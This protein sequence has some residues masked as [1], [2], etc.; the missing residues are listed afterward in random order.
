MRTAAAQ[1]ATVELIL[2]VCAAVD[3]LL[4][5]EH[6]VSHAPVA[7]VCCMSFPLGSRHFALARRAQHAPERALREVQ[8]QQRMGARRTHVFTPE[9]PERTGDMCWRFAGYTLKE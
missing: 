7:A 6:G 2:R 3:R 5:G 8:Q 1:I 9:L 4:Q